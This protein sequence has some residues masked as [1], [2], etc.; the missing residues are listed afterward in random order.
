MDITKEFENRRSLLHWF[1]IDSLVGIKIE[2]PITD[3][4]RILTMQLNGIEI[5]PLKAIER[6]EEQFDK[7]VEEKARELFEELKRDILEPFEDKVK[8]LTDS[9]GLLIT[10]KINKVE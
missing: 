8:E 4:P 5:N 9:V 6:L 2:Q 7:L 10:S 3:I 1:L